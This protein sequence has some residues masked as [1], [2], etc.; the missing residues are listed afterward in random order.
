MKKFETML[1]LGQQRKEFYSKRKG[2][3]MEKINRPNI[4][5]LRRGPPKRYNEYEDDKT[6]LKK[7]YG[8][9]APFAVQPTP[10]NMR[11]YKSI[12]ASKSARSGN[13]IIE[14]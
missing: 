6:G 13:P 4:M 10:P 12:G 5:P 11:H 8:M 2:E 9:F 7:S 1:R 3:I 14:I